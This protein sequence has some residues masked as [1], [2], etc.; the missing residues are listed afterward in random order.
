VIKKIV[1]I[2]FLSVLL[3]PMSGFTEE[4]VDIPVKQEETSAIVKVSDAWIAEAPP[5]ATVLAGYMQLENTSDQEIIISGVQSQDFKAVEIHETVLK[6][7]K[8]SM[9]AHETLSIPAGETVS[10]QPGGLHF[11]LMG[12]KRPLKAGDTTEIILEFQDSATQSVKIEVK[13]RAVE[14]DHQH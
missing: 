14:Q 8:V 12:A 4:T 7:D 1:F 5:T 2:I 9:V 6:A 11:M 3:I 10:L 13:K